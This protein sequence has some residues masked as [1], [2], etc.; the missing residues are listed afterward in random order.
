MF[1]VAV[2]TASPQED[3][4]ICHFPKLAWKKL[5]M[6]ISEESQYPCLKQC[7]HCFSTMMRFVKLHKLSSETSRSRSPVLLHLPYSQ[8]LQQLETHTEICQT[9]MSRKFSAWH[10]RLLYSHCK[11]SNSHCFYMRFPWNPIFCLLLF[12]LN[13]C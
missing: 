5:A 6:P 8:T 2:V 9:S 10:S 4:E 12:R 11:I 1:K 13:I 7:S 3:G